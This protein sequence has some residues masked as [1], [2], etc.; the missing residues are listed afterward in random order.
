MIP[1]AVC[2][3]KPEAV[4]GIARRV[5]CERDVVPV[6]AAL[7]PGREPFHER[8]GVLIHVGRK[9][10][11]VVGIEQANASLK[12]ARLEGVRRDPIEFAVCRQV[13]PDRLVEVA[14]DSDDCVGRVPD[15]ERAVAAARVVIIFGMNNPG[16]AE[17]QGKKGQQAR[18]CARQKGTH[19]GVWADERCIV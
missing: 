19:G 8:V 9:I 7:V 2:H 4:L 11:P 10:Q 16:S 1:A 18:V 13:L 14:V 12:V 5:E 15:R 6:D 17:S 3:R